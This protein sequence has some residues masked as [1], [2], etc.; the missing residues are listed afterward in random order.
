[1]IKAALRGLEWFSGQYRRVLRPVLVILYTLMTGIILYAVFMRYVLNAAPSWSE[2]LAR[3]IMVWAAMLA[4]GIAL[5]QGRHIGLSSLVERLWG[6][7]TRW[8]LLTADLCTLIFF[9]VVF[10]TGI[11]MAI[12][13]LGQRAPS[14]NIT[15][16]IPYVSIPVGAFFLSI[17]TIILI[18][19]K[20]VRN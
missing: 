6:K 18:L 15:M 9:L 10:V 13:V 2:E 4:M 1:M 8:A 16:T 3:Y 5:R 17:E 19:K 12:F 7:H 11:S 14:L 20:L